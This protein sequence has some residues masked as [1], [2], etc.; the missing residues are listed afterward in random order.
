MYRD[1]DWMSFEDFE[2]IKTRAGLINKYKLAGGKI[3]AFEQDDYD[4]VCN[5]ECQFP[6]MRLFNNAIGRKIDCNFIDPDSKEETGIVSRKPINDRELQRKGLVFCYANVGNN[7][8]LEDLKKGLC[9]TI[10]YSFAT[11]D[12]D[13]RILISNETSK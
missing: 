6:I 4:N 11:V 9:H 12:K 13:G 8:Y 10:V 1:T 7:D 5:Y 3:W 2:S